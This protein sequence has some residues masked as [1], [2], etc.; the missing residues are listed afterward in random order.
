MDKKIS[1]II[2]CYNCTLTLKEAVDSIY[3]QGL[4]VPFEVVMV[5]DGSTD[6]TW[7]L[8]QELAKQHHE[9]KIFKHD[10]N[11]GG[12]AARNTAV[13]KSEGE[14]IFGLDSDDILP[15]QMLPKLVGYLE[16]KKCDG[17][18]FAESRFFTRDTAKING[19]A[20]NRDEGRQVKFQSLFDSQ[21]GPLT[22][23]NFLYSRKAF[24]AVGGYTTRHGFDTQDFGCQ[25]LSKGLSVFV[26][27]GSYY[28]HR[29]G[30]KTRSYFERVYA[31]GEYSINIYLIY[32]KILHLFSPSIRKLIADYDIFAN[33]KLVTQN[34]GSEVAKAYTRN[35]EDFFVADLSKYL[36]PDGSRQYFEAHS[37]SV[38]I[39]DV[40]C[41]AI[42]WYQQGRFAEV[43]D[44]YKQLLA[45]GLVSKVIFFNIARAC[46]ALNP[47]ADLTKVEHEAL[48]LLS[49][50]GTTR[51]KIN[52]RPNFLIKFLVKAK[53]AAKHF[54]KAK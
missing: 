49:S 10:K 29:Q 34:L 5:D 3:I 14:L 20:R 41:R 28:F 46:L 32:E 43:L 6:G 8:M 51:Q 12:G 25:F 53:Q 37:S 44:V 40:F 47:Q 54:A 27:P 35:P 18:V 15:P 17:V 30:F 48:E 4:K 7:V 36:R 19:V 52:L 9:I 50:F 1:I 31:S 26:C 13:E 39:T 23:V 33:S 24:E 42:Y 11:L 38:E 45:R 21:A 16:E 2:P 22:T